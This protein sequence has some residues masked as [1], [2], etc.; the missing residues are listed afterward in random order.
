M[1]TISNFEHKMKENR[2][3]SSSPIRENNGIER[4]G[5][6]AYKNW[7]HQLENGSK[8]F[9]VRGG[10]FSQDYSLIAGQLFLNN[11]MKNRFNREINGKT[12]IIGF[13][14]PKFSEENV[15]H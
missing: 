6:N 3:R 8:P 9:H 1:E 4:I 7:C 14:R 12:T 2:L 5:S 10:R 11:N 13:Y 15:F